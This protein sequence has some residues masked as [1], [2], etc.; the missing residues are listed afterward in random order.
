F[1]ATIIGGFPIYEEAWRNICK[2]RMTMELS[3]TLALVAAICIGQFL[4]A[5]VIAFFVLFAELVEGYTVGGGRRAIQTLIDALPRQVR[6]RR[7]GQELEVDTSEAAAG[8]TIILGPGDRIAAD[9]VVSKGHSCVDQSSSTGESLLVEKVEQS[10]VFAGTINKDGVLEVTVEKSG[11]DTTFGK[12]V[13]I[14][15][16][17]EKS[18]A[19]V[20]RIADRLAAGLVY[21]AFIAAV[22]PVINYPN[23]T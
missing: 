5:L 19:P 20:Q 18:R 21:F 14:V 23:L 7:G 3:M 12:I 8:E 13:E 2:R 4:T 22:L 10:K 15:E 9:G 16:Q 6:V 17:A 1:A 11:R